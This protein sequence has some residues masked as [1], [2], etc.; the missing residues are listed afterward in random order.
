MKRKNVDPGAAHFSRLRLVVHLDPRKR[1]AASLVGK[2]ATGMVNQHV[3]HHSACEC[4]KLCFA[5]PLCGGVLGEADVALVDE[6]GG[7]KRVPGRFMGD[8]PRSEATKFVVNLL[9]EIGRRAHGGSIPRGG[10]E[11]KRITHG[12]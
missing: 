7:L 5:Q 4:Q 3:S 1:V 10:A 8:V 6:G 12:E 11:G 9:R 2:L